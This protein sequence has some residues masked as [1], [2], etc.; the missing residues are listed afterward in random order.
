VTVETSARGMS[1]IDGVS[2]GL[3]VRV[4]ATGK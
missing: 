1:V 2:A 3:R 4:P